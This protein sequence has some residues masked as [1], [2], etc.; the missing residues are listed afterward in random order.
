MARHNGQ[1]T[2]VLNVGPLALAPVTDFK[3]M[4]AV[5]AQLFPRYTLFL[6]EA[7]G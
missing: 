5:V 7:A 6:L 2:S 1:Q 4:A 3:L